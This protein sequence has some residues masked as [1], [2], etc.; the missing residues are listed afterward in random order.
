[1]GKIKVEGFDV[2]VE[3]SEGGFTV[4]VPELPGCTVQVD[5]EQ[6]AERGIRP[7]I[8]MYLEELA[9]RKPAM[10]PAGKKARG[11]GGRDDDGG[12]IIKMRRK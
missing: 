11:P 6:D 9:S 4:S 10:P 7:M 2:S 12:N 3:K 1:M 8:G 5:R